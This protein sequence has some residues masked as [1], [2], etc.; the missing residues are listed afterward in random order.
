MGS[1]CGGWMIWGF[2]CVY[3]ASI[4]SLS[5]FLMCYSY[6]PDAFPIL[7]RDVGAYGE[8]S[9]RGRRY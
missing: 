3:D 5:L 2:D 4:V 6:E 1:V 7:G 8:C 9:V